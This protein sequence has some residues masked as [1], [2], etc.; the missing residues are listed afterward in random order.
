MAAYL[1]RRFVFAVL[2]VFSVSSAALVLTRLAPGD[3]ADQTV[4]ATGDIARAAAVRERYG[5]NRPIGVQYADW[6][7][8]A[9]RFDFGRSMVY[10]R[11]VQDLISERAASR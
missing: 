2:L 3:Y 11:P 9:V 8:K 1:A 6:L 10:D 5:L 4:A 7:W